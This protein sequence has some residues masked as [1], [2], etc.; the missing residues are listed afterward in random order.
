MEMDAITSGGQG[1][2][3]R[4]STHRGFH[5]AVWSLRS[6]EFPVLPT[7]SHRKISMI[8]FPSIEKI[9][10]YPPTPSPTTKVGLLTV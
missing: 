4:L 2:V 3:D 10:S 9:R 7:S 1:R 6:L 5:S 8:S